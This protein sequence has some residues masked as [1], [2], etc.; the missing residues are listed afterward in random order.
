M[1]RTEL[2]RTNRRHLAAIFLVLVALSLARPAAAQTVT[3]PDAEDLCAPLLGTP[4]YED[5]LTTTRDALETV[6]GGGTTPPIPDSTIADPGDDPEPA[7]DGATLSEQN[8]EE[9]RQ[10]LWIIVGVVLA[11]VYVVVAWSWIRSMRRMKKAFSPEALALMESMI[12]PEVRAANP[13]ATVGDG[14]T[15]KERKLLRGQRNLVIALLV[16]PAAVFVLL[17]VWEP[18]VDTSVAIGEVA[19]IAPLVLAIPALWW[20]RRRVGKALE[21]GE[22]RWSV[23][24]LRAESGPDVIL[25]P[26]FGG[27]LRAAVVGDTVLT[28]RRYG[29]DVRIEMGSGSLRTLVAAPDVP[30]WPPTPEP[31]PGAA[32]LTAANGWVVLDRAVTGATLAGPDG[33]STVLRDLQRVEQAV[34]ASVPAR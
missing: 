17:Q 4:G 21:A 20:A 7:T 26:R 23:L 32:T 33:M 13:D 1:S 14:L 10:L 34:V 18:S 27:T 16:L 2:A 22:D 28:G 15:E 31:G 11:V 24:G 29:R 8:L 19:R 5:C 9:Q 25:L 30:P 12:P 6:E 3:T